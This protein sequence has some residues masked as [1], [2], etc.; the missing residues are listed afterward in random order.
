M[1]EQEDHFEIDEVDNLID[2]VEMVGH[3]LEI[4]IPYE[5]KWVIIALHQ[6]L[7]GVLISV[8]KGTDAPSVTIMVR[9]LRPII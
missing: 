2:N 6:A 5:W 1:S 3:F 4:P 9:Q 8:L 7:Y